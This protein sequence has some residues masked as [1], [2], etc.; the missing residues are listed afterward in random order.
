MKMAHTRANL[1]ILSVP[2]VSSVASV[3]H[4]NPFLLG[5]DLQI[6]STENLCVLCGLQNHHGTQ[7]PQKPASFSKIFLTKTPSRQLDNPWQE[8]LSDLRSQWRIFRV[9]PIPNKEG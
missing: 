3:V 2:S 4:K 6:S 9:S 7:P 8:Y 1:G 5:K